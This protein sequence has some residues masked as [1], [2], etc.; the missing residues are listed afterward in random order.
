MDNYD[1]WKTGY[2]NSEPM[3]SCSDCDEK[4]NALEGAKSHMKSLIKML[5]REDK[6]S[7]G[8]FESVLDEV[9]AYLG[10]QLP[11]GELMIE[12]K[13]NRSEVHQRWLDFKEE[14]MQ[15]AM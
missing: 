3:F 9:C 7:S 11:S 14:S 6:F 13:K 8:D 12:R 4:E 1:A 15:K 5:Y 10:V 2:Y